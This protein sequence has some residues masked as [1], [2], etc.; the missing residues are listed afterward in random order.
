M[1]YLADNRPPRFPQNQAMS[2]GSAFDAYVKSYL[3]K[4]LFGDDHDPR[5]DLDSIFEAQVDP[6]M[7]DF[8]R[9]NGKYVF[10]QYKQAG[11]LADLMLELRKAQS[12]PRFEFEVK[13][14]VNG[15]REGIE[16]NIG[17]VVLLG[18]PDVHFVNHAGVTVI[19]DFKVN[20]YCSANGASP[21]S[22]YIRMRAAGATQHKQH[23]DC[24]PM[25]HNGMLINIAKY[26]EAQDAKWAQQL[27]IYAWLCGQ[28]VGSDFL[29]AIDQIACKPTPGGLPAIRIAEHRT[30]VSPNFQWSVF[31]R[32][33]TI[34]ETVHS[35]HVFRNMTKAQSKEHC[36]ALD[37]RSL[38]LRGETDPENQWFS[39][40]T[41]GR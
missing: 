31:N 23:K 12:D 24:Q 33:A 20:G 29:V 3:H 36:I 5:F 14:A 41:R 26:L 39:E 15:Y 6:A 10:E 2:M 17:G 34:W 8:A 7:R 28:P 11:C 25:M 18:K 30:R 40:V 32:A 38:D 37:R 4:A 21:L 16:S 19:L 35:D 13:G 22:G 1:N 9:P 27:G